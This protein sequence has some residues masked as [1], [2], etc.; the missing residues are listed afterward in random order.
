MNRL[1]PHGFEATSYHAG[2]AADQRERIQLD[3][4]KSKRGIVVATIAF[5]MGIDKGPFAS[6]PLFPTSPYLALCSGHPS[7]NPSVYA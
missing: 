6:S 7:S 1:M 4:M 2:L 5:G 3:F